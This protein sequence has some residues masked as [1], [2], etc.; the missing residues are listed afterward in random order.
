MQVVKME[1]EVLEQVEG[2]NM[3][4]LRRQ[5]SPDSSVRSPD[6]LMSRGIVHAQEVPEYCIE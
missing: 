2:A 4:Q 6:N 5:E 1:I 3:I